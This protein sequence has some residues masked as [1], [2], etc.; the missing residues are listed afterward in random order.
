MYKATLEIDYLLLHGPSYAMR[1]L[2]PARQMAAFSWHVSEYVWP[3]T[4]QTGRGTGYGCWHSVAHRMQCGRPFWSSRQRRPSP[5]STRLHDSASTWISC[6]CKYASLQLSIFVLQ[7]K[8]CNLF[9]N[10]VWKMNYVYF[11][12]LFYI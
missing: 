7:H 8:R 6:T 9:V 4:P 3:S 10:R 5:Q 2:F 11:A 1:I 12:S